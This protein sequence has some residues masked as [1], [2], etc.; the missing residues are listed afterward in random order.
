MDP[1]DHLNDSFAQ[2]Q[3]IIAAIGISVHIAKVI[4]KKTVWIGK[5]YY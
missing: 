3:F 2:E 1:T 4:A 5:K